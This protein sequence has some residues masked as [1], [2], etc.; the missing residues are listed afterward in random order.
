MTSESEPTPEIKCGPGTVLKDGVCVIDERCGPGTVLKDGICQVVKK[1]LLESHYMGLT[2]GVAFITALINL[3]IIYC[4]SYRG[5]DQGLGLA[6]IGI[7]TFFGVSLSSSIFEEHRHEHGNKPETKRDSNLISNIIV[8]KG[9]MRKGL[10][11]SLVMTYIVLIGLSFSAG[12]LDNPLGVDDKKA[13]PP[14]NETP[15]GS[16]NTSVIINLEQIGQFL[17]DNKQIDKVQ[18]KTMDSDSKVIEELILTKEPDTLVE[19][20]TIVISVVIGFYFGFNAVSALIKARKE[21]KTSDDLSK[22]NLKSLP[23]KTLEDV[24]KEIKAI[25]EK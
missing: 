16:N 6:A 11:A 9:I 17:N 8:G 2:T 3:A 10:A 13:G 22:N 24:A 15:S 21:D 12:T 5:L 25:L 19:H 23:K 7:I 14:I 20:F 18:I 4:M 1:S